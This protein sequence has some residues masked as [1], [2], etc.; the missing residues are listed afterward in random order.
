MRA[1]F[2]VACRQ[3]SSWLRSLLSKWSCE[4][5]CYW[6]QCLSLVNYEQW[7]SCHLTR[8]HTVKLRPPLRRRIWV[9]P[10]KLLAFQKRAT[11]GKWQVCWS[12]VLLSQFCCRARG[13][14][15]ATLPN[16]WFVKA[17]WGSAHVRTTCSR[18]VFVPNHQR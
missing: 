2:S 5:S 8:H 14:A 9:D 15:P 11:L 7:R 17:S 3:D 4:S 12:A 13:R 18:L 16:F 10:M 1:L 6:K